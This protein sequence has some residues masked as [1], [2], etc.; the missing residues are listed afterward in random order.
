MWHVHA[1]FQLQESPWWA[2][3]LPSCERG[4]PNVPFQQ[5]CPHVL[6]VYV[7]VLYLQDYNLCHTPHVQNTENMVRGSSWQ[8]NTDHVWQR[9]RKWKESVRQWSETPVCT[10]VP[11]EMG[12]LCGSDHVMLEP[13][14]CLRSV[15]RNSRRKCRAQTSCLKALSWVKQLNSTA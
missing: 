5:R 6:T 2:Q 15:G 11:G 7:H 8:D 10:C 13:S 14:E 9:D 3:K 4:N 12:G 1:T